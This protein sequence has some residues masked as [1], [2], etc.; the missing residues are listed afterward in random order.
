MK[1]LYEKIVE[2]IKFKL[3]IAITYS[4]KLPKF[5]KN[6]YLILI[7]DII[8]ERGTR[9]IVEDYQPYKDNAYHDGTSINIIRAYKDSEN[10]LLG[11]VTNTLEKKLS[12]IVNQKHISNINYTYIKIK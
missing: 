4:G 12:N 2:Y 6:Y 10:S 9:K 8:D 1:E 11:F 5:R 7:Y 3:G